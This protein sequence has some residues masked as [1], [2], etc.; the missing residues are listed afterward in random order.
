M[1]NGNLS[2]DLTAFLC[3]V[4]MFSIICVSPLHV[5]ERSASTNNQLGLAPENYNL[6]LHKAAYM[7]MN[8]AEVS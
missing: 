1:R 7:K 2:P 6:K 8:Q 3:R 5:L 4:C